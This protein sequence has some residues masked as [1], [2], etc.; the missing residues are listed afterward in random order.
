MA[1]KAAK[2]KRKSVEAFTHDGAKRRNIPTAEYQPVM[3]SD[4]QNPI[5]VASDRC[6]LDLGRPP[7]HHETALLSA[8]LI[9]DHFEETPLEYKA[10]VHEDEEADAGCRC[11]RSPAAP[12][13]GSL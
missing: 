9:L 1:K 13:K 6:N 2:A 3:R 4:G 10:I 5:Q 12:P 8:R 11:R 7:I